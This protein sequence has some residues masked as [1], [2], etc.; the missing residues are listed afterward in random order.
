[1]R[2]IDADALIK[3]IAG[4]TIVNNH[5][6]Q[7]ANALCKL[8]QDQPTAYDVD[9]VVKELEEW[10][11]NADICLGNDTVINRDLITSVNAIEIVKDGGLDG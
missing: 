7:K 4:M 8:I 9:G 6:P 2:L 1:M 11:F 3:Q 5:P 10:T